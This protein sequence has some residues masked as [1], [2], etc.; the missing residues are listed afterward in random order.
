MAIHYRSIILMNHYHAIMAKLILK[1]LDR[2]TILD[3]S[4]YI[5]LKILKFCARPKQN[6]PDIAFGP[7]NFIKNSAH[8]HASGLF[9]FYLVCVYEICVDCRR[10]SWCRTGIKALFLDNMIIFALYRVIYCQM[11]MHSITFISIYMLLFS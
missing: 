9:F 11:H 10:P 1:A 2:T 4:Y 3:F 8:V 6:L 5:Q 7:A